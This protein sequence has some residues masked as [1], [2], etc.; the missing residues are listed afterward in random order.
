MMGW[1]KIGI[2]LG[3]TA[4][5]LGACN[6]ERSFIGFE[7]AGAPPPSF[8]PID[9]G[10]DV[11]EVQELAALCAATECPAPYATCGDTP[12]LLCTTNLSADAENCGACG[13][14]CTGYG[15][16]LNLGARCVQGKCA[17]ECI[18]T[19]T[20]FRDCN[21]ILDDGCETDIAKDPTNCGICGR[22]C[23]PGVRCVDGKCG[24]PS[25]KRDCDGL[26]ID[27]TTNP[28]NCGACGN[29]CEDPPDACDPTPPNTVYS[30]A[31]GQCGRLVCLGRNGDCNHDL[32]LGC[33]SDGCETNLRNNPSNCGNCGVVCG[34]GQECRDDGNGMECLDVCS[35]SGMQK[36]TLGCRDLRSDPTSCGACGNA[37][38]A[39]RAH[40]IASC[41]KGVCA[42]ECAPGFADCNGDPMDGCE[43]DLGSHPGNCGTCG[44]EC[45]FAA[46]QPCVDGKCLMGP[47]DAG[48]VTK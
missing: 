34:P 30:C 29:V 46:G 14:S 7:D 16:G 21:G 40:Q 23:A 2:A 41:T 13:V 31:G 25:G 43:V 42:M 22:T 47:C 8:T 4:L 27:V 38:P 1:R 32:N 9:A 45:N 20:K 12:S 19:A 26:C 15:V 28:E 24:C 18:N 33:A 11:V 6:S 37:C 44:H 3:A 17:F 35:T 36:C 39:A 48:V 10:A 5:V